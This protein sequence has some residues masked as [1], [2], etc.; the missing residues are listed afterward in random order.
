VGGI[1]ESDVDLAAASGASIIGFN[2]R[3]DRRARELA[4]ARKVEIRTLRDHLQA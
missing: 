1:T 4:D 3:P 2:V